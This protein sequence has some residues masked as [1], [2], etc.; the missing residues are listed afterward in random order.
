MFGG[1]LSAA[2]SLFGGVGKAIGS[3]AGP[4]IGAAG[5]L[6]GGNNANDSAA[7]LRQADYQAQ[8]EFAQHGIRWKVAD[9]KAAGLHPLAAIGGTGATFTPSG[10]S[11]G[12]SGYGA[13]AGHIGD[14]LTQM[15]QNT[16]RAQNATATQHER[17]IADLSLERAKLQNRL[18]EAQI[19]SEWASVMGQPGNPPMPTA[20][21]PSARTA[22]IVSRGTS[23]IAGRSGLV[24]TDP[25]VA[26]SAAAADHSVEAATTPA[27][28]D[29]PISRNLS[30]RLP[31]QAAS[32]SLEQMGPLAG[33]GA[34][35][36]AALDKG[37]K[38]G[39]KPNTEL[40]PGYR[41][42]W[43]VVSQSWKPVRDSSAKYRKNLGITR[44]R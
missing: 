33:P 43:S 36:A 12:D 35:L 39:N 8:K 29:F 9:A 20:V 5:S 15:G 3:V 14:A 44:G 2:G 13:A 7:A 23:P 6:I 41:W 24:Q 1:L 11:V 18:L 42:E 30:L 17:E 32:E 21:N 4:L 16:K 28:K 10:Y 22:A 37:F 38:G 31:S 27:W 26:I 19:N 34:A 25:S 40:P